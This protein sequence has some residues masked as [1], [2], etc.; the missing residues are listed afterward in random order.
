LSLLAPEDFYD[1]DPY[2]I[3]IAFK[4][5]NINDK[6]HLLL[7]KIYSRYDNDPYF[8]H[9]LAKVKIDI[10]NKNYRG[11]DRNWALI[12]RLRIEAIELL[13]KAINLFEDKSQK[14]WCW[15]DLARTLQFSRQPTSSVEE[16]YKNAMSL[17]PEEKTFKKYYDRWKDYIR[18]KRVDLT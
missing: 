15:F 6:A 3:A 16:A 17:L 4:R 8:L 12:R 5:L 9:D 11:R 18:N 2:E 10:A 13:R 1:D 14:A 7:S